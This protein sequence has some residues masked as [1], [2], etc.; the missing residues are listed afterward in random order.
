M[1]M[2]PEEIVREYRTA[3]HKTEQIKI[4]ADL[5]VCSRGEIA[6]ILDEAGEKIDKR[7]L[8]K[9]LPALPTETV[10][11]PEPPS[12]PPPAELT[13]ETLWMITEGVRGDALLT[14]NGRSP[15]SVRL[16]ADF[17]ADGK[18]LRWRVDLSYDET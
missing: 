12:P 9:R 14:I 1:Q 4:L 6:R 15:Q 11:A 3:K 18:A 8:S 10:S 13:L 2:T 17:A 7:F 16:Q 5:N